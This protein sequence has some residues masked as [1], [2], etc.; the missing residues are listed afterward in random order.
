MTVSEIRGIAKFVLPAL[1][2]RSARARYVVSLVCYL[3]DSGSDKGQPIVALGGYITPF[4]QWQEFEA[5]AGKYLLDQGIEYIHAIDLRKGSGEF[6]GWGEPDRVK[7]LAELYEIAKDHVA[8]GA[9]C[10]VNRKQHNA[11]KTVLDKSHRQSPAGFAFSAILE[12]IIRDDGVQYAINECSYDIQF[13]LE[14]GCKYNPEILRSYQRVKSDHALPFLAGMSNVDKK[15]CV[16]V[17]LADVHAY[18][19][20][21]HCLSFDEAGRNPQENEPS[22]FLKVIDR[23]IPWCGMYVTNF[24]G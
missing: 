24:L 6:S 13:L 2:R 21:R 8:L 19:K 3:D 22:E 14:D 5:K 15:S 20:W 23:Q 7:F 17:Q 4:D 9:F 16:A 10:A 18:F 11:Q 12:H 1:G